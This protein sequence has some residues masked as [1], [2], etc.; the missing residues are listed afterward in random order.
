MGRRKC[1]EDFLKE[2]ETYHVKE[3]RK[4]VN[5][6]HEVIMDRKMIDY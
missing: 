3:A 2:M 6:L 1:I 4:L 5:H